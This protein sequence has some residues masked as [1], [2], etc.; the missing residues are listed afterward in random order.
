MIFAPLNRLR[1]YVAR[2]S[3]SNKKGLIIPLM[4]RSVFFLSN[5]AISIEN[6]K[7]RNFELLSNC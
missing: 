1:K 7:T 3:Q 6:D 2:Q 5:V 4:E